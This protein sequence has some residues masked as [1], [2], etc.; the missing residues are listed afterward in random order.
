V[1]LASEQ[2]LKAI[3]FKLANRLLKPF[4][5]SNFTASFLVIQQQAKTKNTDAVIETPPVD[6]VC[7]G[8]GLVFLL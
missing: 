7:C 6:G 8:I 3:I 4:K 1:D 5:D 2:I